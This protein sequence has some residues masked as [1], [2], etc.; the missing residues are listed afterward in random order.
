MHSYL[1]EAPPLAEP[2]GFLTTAYPAVLRG[3]EAPVCPGRFSTDTPF[4]LGLA[5][6]PT[7]VHFPTYQPVQGTAGPSS[8]FPRPGGPRKKMRILSFYNFVRS[9]SSTRRFRRPPTRYHRVQFFTGIPLF[10]PSGRLP[11]YE[12]DWRSEKSPPHFSPFP[13][14]PQVPSSSLF[15][16]FFFSHSRP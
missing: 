2:T 12:V 9:F 10:T 16:L 15:C 7:T 8:F 1:T 11:Y 3:P 5:V 6:P 14:L 4:V 13:C